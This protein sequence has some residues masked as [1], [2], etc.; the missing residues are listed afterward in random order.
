MKELVH[1][2]QVDMEKRV[3]VYKYWSM[4]Y[5]RWQY[6]VIPE[7]L[8]R[9]FWPFRLKYSSSLWGAPG[10]MLTTHSYYKKDDAVRAAEDIARNYKKGI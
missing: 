2:E 4:E 6:N 9:W 5:L 10:Q 1:T 7:E 3:A 8:F